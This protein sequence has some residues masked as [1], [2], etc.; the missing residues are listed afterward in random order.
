[1]KDL[2]AIALLVLGLIPVTVAAVGIYQGQIWCVPHTNFEFKGRWI[3]RSKE[4][5]RFWSNTLMIGI[6]GV[7]C[8]V[9]GC[10]ALFF[11]Q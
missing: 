4:A 2:G 3:H 6:V 9:A 8:I 1:M 11:R 10:R 7:A 5:S